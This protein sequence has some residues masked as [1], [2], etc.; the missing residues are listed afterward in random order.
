[1]E[2]HLVEDHHRIGIQEEMIRRMVAG[3]G[4]TTMK[5]EQINQADPQETDVR[6]Q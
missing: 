5:I 2:V 3:I 4:V 1:M 6:G